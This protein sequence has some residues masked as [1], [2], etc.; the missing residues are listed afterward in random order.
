MSNEVD[1]RDDPGSS[2][3]SEGDIKTIELLPN[4]DGINEFSKETR[5]QQL[6]EN[7]GEGH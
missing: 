2:S 4:K 5:S 7:R 6:V 1:D 3:D